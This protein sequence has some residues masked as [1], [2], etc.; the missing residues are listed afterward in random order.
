MWNRPS[1]FS[2]C[3]PIMQL[4]RSYQRKSRR[5]YL[6]FSVFPKLFQYGDFFLPTYGVLVAL[7]FLAGMWVTT[8]LAR[9]AGINHELVVNLAVYCALSGLLGAKLLMFIFDWDHF[10]KNPADMFSVATLRA[11]GVY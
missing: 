8:R 9:R 1:R 4:R 10:S 6:E 7:A 11:A 2:I 3:E 5:C